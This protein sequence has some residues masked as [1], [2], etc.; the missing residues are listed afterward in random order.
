[1][2]IEFLADHPAL[3]PILAQWHHREWQHLTPGETIDEC[4]QRLRASAQRDG[5]PLTVIALADGELAGSAS[6]VAHDMEIRRDLTPWLSGVYVTPGRRRR[7]VGSALVRR[8]TREAAR[9]GVATLYLFTTSPENERLYASLGW[10]V[11]ERVEYLG[12]RRVIMETRT[13]DEALQSP[14]L[15][16]D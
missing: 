7:G 2:R 3:V 8:V 5:C 10:S 14:A 15:A 11:R 16:R 13:P 6:L 4:A 9:L 12:R 1:M